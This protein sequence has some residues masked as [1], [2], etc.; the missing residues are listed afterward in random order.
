VPPFGLGRDPHDAERHWVVYRKLMKLRALGPTDTKIPAV[1]QGTMGIG[2]YFTRDDSSDA[3]FI[4]LLKLGFDL[5]LRLIDTA[6]GY[7]GGHS[8]EIVGKAVHGIREKVFIATKCSSEHSAY[9]LVIRSA[10][11]SLRRLKTDWIDLYQTH[12]PDPRVPIE[13]TMRAMEELVEAGKIRY[14]GLSNCSVAEARRA[15]DCLSHVPLVALQHEYS[16]FE[17][18]VETQLLPWCSEH[19]VTLLA[20]SPLSRG[21]ILDGQRKNLLDVLGRKYD[22]SGAQL[23]LNWLLENPSVVV[24]PKASNEL[25]LRENAA[26]LDRT[27]DPA[28]HR[29]ISELFQPRIVSIPTDEIE[30]LEENGRQ[31]Y[32][33]LQEA[34]ENRFNIVPGPLD[35]SEQVASGEILKPIKVRV[36]SLPFKKPPYQLVE[37]RVR[38]WAWVIAYKGGVPIPAI[39]ENPEE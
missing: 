12:W 28:D 39:V 30:V 14:I 24:I 17:R 27:I 33:T 31:I 8:E 25:H 5:G 29:K 16:V 18:T 11:A 34:I 23:F 7:G 35:L 26:V 19:Q 37:G 4:R 2:G 13:E 15:Q 3:E 22:L 36:N 6:E 32:K 9:D 1:G 21:K 10:E 20:Y 38:Y